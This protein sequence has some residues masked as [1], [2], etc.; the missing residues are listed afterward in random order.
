MNYKVLCTP[1]MP[2]AQ[3][4]AIRAR[5]WPRI[6][7]DRDDALAWCR[8]INK[9][10]GISWSIEDDDGSRLTRWD[11]I[12]EINKRSNELVGRPKKY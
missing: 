4:E 10:G 9:H 7:D 8:D 1:A 11:I 6:Y 2:E 5:I 3:F 12:D